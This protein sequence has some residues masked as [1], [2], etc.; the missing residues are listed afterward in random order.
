MKFI[1]RALLMVFLS[2]LIIFS[3]SFPSLAYVV[4]GHK[5]TTSIRNATYT[6]PFNADYTYNGTTVDYSVPM[7]N[8]NSNWYNNVPSYYISCTSDHSK[9]NIDFFVSNFGNIGMSAYTEF[10]NWAGT[11][12]CSTGN[13]PSTNWDW[14]KI[15]LNA[16]DMQS[17]SGENRNKICEHEIGHAIGLHHV[18]DTSR[19]MYPYWNQCTAGGVTSDEIAGATALYP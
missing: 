7:V 4:D 15:K 5:L 9:S 8:A 12:L 11:Q 10:Y 17:I 19:L 14:C 3:G 6:I 1:K 16:Y 2:L 18:Y 13:M